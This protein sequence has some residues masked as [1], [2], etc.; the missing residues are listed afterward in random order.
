[1]DADSSS[2]FLLEYLGACFAAVRTTLPE[3]ISWSHPS[4]HSLFEQ[5]QDRSTVLDND[6]QPRPFRQHRKVN[7]SKTKARQEDIDT[8]ANVLIVQRRN[9]LG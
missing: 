7:S 4:E 3:K 5:R 8:I 2:I 1:M 9:C 6:P